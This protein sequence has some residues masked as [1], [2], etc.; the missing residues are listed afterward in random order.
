MYAAIVTAALAVNGIFSWLGLIPQTRPSIDSIT[1]RG[2]SWNYT[3]ALNILFTLVAAAL[4][5]LT[6]RA[7][8]GH[9][10]EAAHGG[11]SHGAGEETG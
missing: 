1:G 5:A 4:V 7:S 10:R 6:M 11:L 2:I 3:T 8:G 9:A